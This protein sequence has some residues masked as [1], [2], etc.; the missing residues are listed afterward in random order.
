MDIK[1]LKWRPVVR[2]VTSSPL[3]REAQGSILGAFTLDIVLNTTSHRCDISSKG[4]V[5]PAASK[6]QSWGPQT[7]LML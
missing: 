1:S 4:V 5:L 2:F 3:K 7:R 6:A